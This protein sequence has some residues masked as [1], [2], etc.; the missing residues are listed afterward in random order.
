[1]VGMTRFKPRILWAKILFNNIF[2]LNTIHI[3]YDVYGKSSDYVVITTTNGNEFTD[4]Q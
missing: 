2:T 3:T 1:M 4:V